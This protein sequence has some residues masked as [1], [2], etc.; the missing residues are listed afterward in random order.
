MNKTTRLPISLPMGETF[1]DRPWFDQNGVKQHKCWFCASGSE[2]FTL[3]P[4]MPPGCT[5]CAR[6]G[7]LIYTGEEDPRNEAMTVCRSCDRAIE[8]EVA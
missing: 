6:C 5:L 1:G 2:R 4:P 8:R 3:Y 7:V